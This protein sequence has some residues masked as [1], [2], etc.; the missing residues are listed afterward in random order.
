MTKIAT[1]C[2]VVS[3]GN[4]LLMRKKRGFGQGKIIAHGGR[5]ENDETLRETAVLEVLE[6]TGIR[7]I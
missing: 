5:I 1:L 6:E 3:N 7:P 4:V 2:F